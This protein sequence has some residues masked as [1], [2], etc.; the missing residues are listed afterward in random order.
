METLGLTGKPQ[1]LRQAGGEPW[2]PAPIPALFSLMDEKEGAEPRGQSVPPGLELRPW[3]SNKQSTL[4]RPS[5]HPPERTPAGQYSV[6]RADLVF[7]FPGQDGP[8][9]GAD[10]STP[11]EHLG[12]GGA[13]PE[14]PGFLA[15]HLRSP[16]WHLRGRLAELVSARFPEDRL[17]SPPPGGSPAEI[18]A[19][20]ATVSMHRLC[21]ATRGTRT[22]MAS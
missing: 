6:S 11:S 9:H 3:E 12:H 19:A 8:A 21:C 16:S 15:P 4:C 20:G 1:A 2:T 7:L 18:K 17:A 22:E 13:G 10:L 14:G 5:L